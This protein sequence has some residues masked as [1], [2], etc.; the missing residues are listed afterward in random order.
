MRSVN[1]ILCDDN[2][3]YL[4]KIKTIIEK[5]NYKYN[6]NSDIYLFEDYSDEFM[7]VM[8]NKLTN[9]IYILDI[10]TPTHSG[11][12]IANMIRKEDK[13]SIIIFISSHRD[14]AGDIAMELIHSLTFVSKLNN[15]DQRIEEALIEALDNLED[16]TFLHFQSD[17]TNYH[18]KL[19]NILYITYDSIERK[20]LIH[21]DDKHTFKSN[22]TLSRTF[23][24]LDKRFCYSQRGCIVNKHRILSDN[25]EKITFD[26][27]T[28]ID[29]ISDMFYQKA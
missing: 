27:G 3:K 12:D 1:Y 4:Q 8:K 5:I 18:I 16:E 15:F 23:D 7:R 11:I 2:K 14:L 25:R 26:T 17:D 24:Q 19:Q 20:T 21:T 6:V 10:D 9:K 29:S 13:H 22:Q 28:S